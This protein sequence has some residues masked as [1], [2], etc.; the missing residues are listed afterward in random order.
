MSKWAGKFVI[1]LTG[2][3]GTG[4]SV[5]RRMLEHLGA[6]GIDADALSH[7][8]IARGA[9]GYQKVI[10]L[11]GKF[12]LDANG[13]IDRQRL[14]RLVFSDAEALQN[15][16][17]IVHP[18]VG[19]AVDYL[20]SRSSHTVVVVEAI[21]LLESG[22]SKDCDATWV[23]YTPPEVQLRRLMKQRGMLEGDARQR[24]LAQPPQEKKIA[25]ANV[26]IRNIGSYE[27]TWK[28]VV[29]AWRKFVPVVEEGAALKTQPGAKGEIL[30]TRG[31]PRNSQE[32]AGLL[33]RLR[34]RPGA[35][36]TE[37]DIMETFGEKAFLMLQIDQSL[38]G[39]VGWQVENLVSRTT[40]M[41][42]DPVIPL[43]RAVPAMVKEMERASQDLQCEAS[44]IF[45]SPDL[46]RHEDIWRG[47]GYQI[48]KPD[49]LEVMAWQDAAR[50]SMPEGT[51]LLFKKLRQ[52]RVL[53]PI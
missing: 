29:T 10:D 47:L 46:A 22:L 30:V 15:L 18:L 45:V 27:D 7:R 14:G 34:K 49:G 42:V 6:Y 16:E 43:A 32:I 24:I 39:L 52:D 50:K 38:K 4:K 53:R 51:V 40:D 44:L 11:F 3:I 17:A 31:R 8:T 2:N 5:V 12:M 36:I 41:V 48:A 21:K 9:P 1:G 26:V 23:V 28:Q 20:I 35:A 19:Q 13:E 37:A 25:A 33:N